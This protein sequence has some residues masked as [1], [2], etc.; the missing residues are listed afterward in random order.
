MCIYVKHLH[1]SLSYR[2]HHCKISSC[3]H[4]IYVQQKHL[5]ISFQP[6]SLT[7]QRELY[8][9]AIPIYVM[10]EKEK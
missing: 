10:V 8:S 1:K 2:F 7:Y 3:E 4:C 5:W 9:Y 6:V